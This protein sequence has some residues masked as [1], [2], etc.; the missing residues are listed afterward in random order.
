VN[1]LALIDRCRENQD[2][3]GLCGAIPY[4]RYLGIQA[5]MEG[6]MLVTTLGFRQRNIGNPALPALHG[7]VIGAHLE[8]AAVLQL[9]WEHETG[10]IPKTINLT[11]DYLRPGAARD[12]YARGVVTKQGRRIANVSVESWQEH[13]DRLIASANCHFLL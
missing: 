1:L 10:K 9:L 4:A 5:H 8:T 3:E 11:V 6:G 7:G 13:P 2:F 12:T